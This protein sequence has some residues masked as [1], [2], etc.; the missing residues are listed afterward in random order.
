MSTPAAAG[1]SPRK[2]AATEFLRLAA[3]GDVRRAFDTYAHDSFRH[4]NPHFPG[5]ATSLA[6]AM[7]E[8]A[9]QFPEKRLGIERVIEEGEL[10]AVHARV[11]MTPDAA[12]IALVHI[13][14]FEGDRVI[15][16]WDVSQ[17]PPERSA[18][19]HGMF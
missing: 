19:Q 14:R 10:V 9:A 7:A 1:L 16:L 11:R 13:F 17:A 6:T 3:A 2:Q 18:N 5:D 4:H 15:E 8:N 12:D